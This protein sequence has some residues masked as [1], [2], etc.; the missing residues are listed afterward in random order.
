[1][2]LRIFET[3]PEAA[4]KKRTGPSFTPDFR[5]RGGLVANGQP[6][7]LSTWAFTTEDPTIAPT[8]AEKFGGEVEVLDVEKGD[9]Q[10][11]V[12]ETASVDVLIDG[13]KSLSTVMVLYGM[14]GPIHKC[15]GMYSLL[16]DEEG[17]PCGCPAGFAERKAL[18]KKGRGPSP[19]I[20]LTFQ[21]ADAPDLGIGLY[22][23]GSWSLVR[24]LPEI[25]REL[26]ARAGDTPI[27]ARLKLV[28]VEFTTKAGMDVSYHRPVVEFI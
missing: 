1:M 14:N 19:E 16:E 10:R 22:R 26:E 20:K 21:L 8:F 18:A 13:P 5:L 15:D 23:T 7:A 12:T 24:D 3:D 25:E 11:I 17:E 6:V 27:R 9:D 28:L 4:A 2:S